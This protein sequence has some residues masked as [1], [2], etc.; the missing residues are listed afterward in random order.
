MNLFKNLHAGKPQTVVVYGTSLTEIGEWPNALRAYFD[1]HY[2]G[3]V[4]VINSAACGQHS[5]WGRM[6]LEDRVLAKHP[7]LVFIEFSVN[8]AATKHS[9]PLAQSGINLHAMVNAIEAQNPKV[10]LILQTMSPVWDWP[11]DPLGKRSASD[12]PYLEDYYELYRQYAREADLPLID[13]YPNW[14]RIQLEDE[15]KFQAWLPDGAH[16][17]PEASLAITWPPIEQMLDAARAESAGS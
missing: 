16:P 1:R 5:F 14:R 2:P 9:I 11:G 10:D 15:Q 3:Q 17:T 13:H 6:N 8:D 7:D 4:T 12:R